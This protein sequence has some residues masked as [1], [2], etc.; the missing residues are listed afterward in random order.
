[1]G[2]FRRRRDDDRFL[3]P[4]EVPSATL[5]PLPDVDLLRAYAK[6]LGQLNEQAWQT[7]SSMPSDSGSALASALVSHWWSEPVDARVTNGVTRGVRLGLAFAEIEQGQANARAGY[8]HP[9]IHACLGLV[10]TSLPDEL[11][12]V[13]DLP[14]RVAYSIRAG[15]YYG[16]VGDA[17]VP[18]LVANSDWVM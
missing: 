11:N 16:R 5:I 6:E 1:V 13:E 2:L 3:I 12:E 8:V 4:L 9:W 18:E 14:W 17:S 15:Y 10:G 7:A